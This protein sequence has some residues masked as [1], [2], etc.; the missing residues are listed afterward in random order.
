MCF[1]DPSYKGS[2]NECMA[3]LQ[4]VNIVKGEVDF[5]VSK[6]PGEETMTNVYVVLF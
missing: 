6:K 3:D 1:L 5:G 2:G 4:R